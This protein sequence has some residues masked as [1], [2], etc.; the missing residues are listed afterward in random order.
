[1]WWTVAMAMQAPAGPPDTAVRPLVIP[2]TA[3]TTC[4]DDPGDD[5]VVCGR[6]DR[7]AF[8]LKPL[9]ERYRPADAMPQAEMTIAGKLKMAAEAEAGQAAGGGAPPRAMVRLKLPF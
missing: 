5:V 3:G 8:R 7:D 9:P 2:T 4:G 6:R 1:M